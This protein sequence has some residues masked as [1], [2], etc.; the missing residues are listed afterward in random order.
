MN[1]EQDLLN[2]LSR[3]AAKHQIKMVLFTPGMK[4]NP[5]APQYIII[6][7]TKNGPEGEV[8]YQK[9]QEQKVTLPVIA[10]ADFAEDL[11]EFRKLRSKSQV[12]YVVEKPLKA[13]ELDA[14]FTALQRPKELLNP[15]I[16][17]LY[18]EYDKT[19][20]EKIH[21]LTTL[22]KL[23]KHNS[24]KE[25]VVALRAAIHK[26]AGNA[27]TY[28]YNS[29]SI[30]ANELQ[31]KI[32]KYLEQGEFA[33]LSFDE[34]IKNL[35]FYLQ[36]RDDKPIDA[37]GKQVV[38][39]TDILNLLK[40]APVSPTVTKSVNVLTSEGI[41][42]TLTPKTVTLNSKDIVIV[43]DDPSVL[44]YVKQVFSIF[45]YNVYA[46]NGGNA[47]LQFL[48]QCKDLQSCCM[49]I[50]DLE[51]PDIDGLSILKKLKE[52]FG[53]VRVVFLSSKFSSEIVEEVKK[54]GAFDF[55]QKPFSSNV[56]KEI[57]KHKV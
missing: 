49:V 28:G 50:L 41:K 4:L 23:Q 32:D 44:A 22:S 7:F 27:G 51:M 3:E 17:E 14:L 39:S 35:A 34:D 9:L 45:G 21:L 42:N 16:K 1:I 47:G 26:I 25:S 8:I 12:A 13:W 33:N 36:I 55:I 20:G 11:A 19:I 30:Y 2:E 56:M 18:D 24:T 6:D 40:G 10:L 31:N 54:Y 38:T 48:M 43:D 37:D 15:K 5:I 53:S 46:F 29:A 57:L 52:K